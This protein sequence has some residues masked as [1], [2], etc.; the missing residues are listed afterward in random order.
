MPIGTKPMNPLNRTPPPAFDSHIPTNP[1]P[2]H[3]TCPSVSE[4]NFRPRSP[5][6]SSGGRSVLS[7]FCSRAS[8][9]T[10]MYPEPT[11]RA[12]EAPLH[13][14]AGRLQ[15]RNHSDLIPFR[16]PGKESLQSLL[17]T[18]QAGNTLAHLWSVSRIAQPSVVL[19]TYLCISLDPVQVTQMAKYLETVYVSGW[20]SSSTASSTNEPGP[21]LAGASITLS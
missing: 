1:S 2:H 12:G 3:T 20:Q 14:R 6:S 16:Y 15:A 19:H 13:R 11:L 10:V 7:P 18:L 5:R 4:H 8:P 17:G 9:S 21:D